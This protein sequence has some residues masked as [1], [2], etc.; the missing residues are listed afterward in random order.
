MGSV[1]VDNIKMDGNT[2]SSL[3][4]AGNINLSPASGKVVIDTIR[5]VATKDLTISPQTGQ[6]VVIG[7]AAQ[8]D[9]LRLDGNTL[10]SVGSNKDINLSPD[11]TGSVIIGTSLTV[12]DLVLDGR[13]ITAST[14]D[15][16]LAPASGGSVRLNN[17]AIV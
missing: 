4:T 2:I 1:V 11:G 17:A 8:V 16:T 3:D 5:G 12:D 13:T 6:S 10:S 7:E 9:N 14:G 15:I